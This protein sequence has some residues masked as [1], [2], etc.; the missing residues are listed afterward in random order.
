[1]TATSRIVVDRQ[2]DPDNELGSILHQ[3]GYE[4]AYATGTP[5]TDRQEEVEVA[6]I[7]LI[8]AGEADRLARLSESRARYPKAGVIVVTDAT[9]PGTPVPAPAGHIVLIY[10]CHSVDLNLLAYFIEGVMSSKYGASFA[11]KAAILEAK[12]KSLRQK[13]HYTW[14][15]LMLTGDECRD[16]LKRLVSASAKA[17]NIIDGTPNRETESAMKS[18]RQSAVS[19]RCIVN[20]YLNLAELGN[21]KLFIHPTLIDPVR[22]VLE[23]ILSSYMDLLNE[24]GQTCQFRNNRPD[25]LIWADKALL[26]NVYDNLIHN[27]LMFGNQGGTIIFTVMER[28]NVDELSVWYSGQ[29]LDSRCLE[30][31]GE[32]LTYGADDVARRNAEIGIYLASKIV[33]A[34]G[35]NLWAEAQANSWMNF[36]FTLPKREVAIRERANHTSDFCFNTCQ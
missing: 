12:S 5:D 9:L 14:K 4:I 18:V 23:P 34:H 10:L 35:G 20:N 2:L 19:M 8:G 29:G 24:R 32:R 7:D 26:T 13:H 3:Q 36:I 28:G 27:A 21:Q 22:D 15:I 30:A 6:V 17:L 25:L 11:D 33:E 31:L 16:Q 1:M